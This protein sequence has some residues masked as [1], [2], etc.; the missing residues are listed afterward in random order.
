ML[1]VTDNVTKI[2]G[3][4][5]QIMT[6]LTIL[7]SSFKVTLKKEF[8]LSEEDSNRILAK[9][10]DIAFMDGPT[11]KRFLDELENKNEENNW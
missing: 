11:R 2:E 1:F 4:P 6:E 7:L 5:K 10:Y 9:A 8:N 3:D